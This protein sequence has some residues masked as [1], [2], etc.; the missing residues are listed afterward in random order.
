VPLAVTAHHHVPAVARHGPTTELLAPATCSFPQ[1]WLLVAV[2]H[3]GTTV[4]LVPAAD[5]PGQ[6]AAYRHATT[7]KALGRGIARMAADRL[8]R[9][10]LAER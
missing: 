3:D 1:A 5:G 9:L 6:A 7:G 8:E 4:R 2:G 10:P